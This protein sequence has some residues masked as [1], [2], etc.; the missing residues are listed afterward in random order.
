MSPQL[1]LS[2]RRRPLTIVA[3]GTAAFAL[4]LRYALDRA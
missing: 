3:L 2:M 1:W 4:G